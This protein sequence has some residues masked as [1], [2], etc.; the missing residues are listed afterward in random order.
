MLFITKQAGWFALGILAYRAFAGGR[1]PN[2]REAVL[3]VMAV[4]ACLLDDRAYVTW[5]QA[6]LGYAPAWS[7][8][9]AA[10][11]IVV[12]LAVLALA[13]RLPAVLPPMVCLALGGLTY[14]LYLVHQNL[15]YAVMHWL[16]PVGG[17]WVGLAGAV[18]VVT[19]LAWLIHRGVEPVGKRLIVR[20]GEA[21]RGR[22]KRSWSS[23]QAAE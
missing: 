1:S 13:V 9:F 11:K 2:L 8:V 14:P 15:G 6:N 23:V 22:F 5:M 17:R 3:G 12:M 4:A 19:A 21:V 18:I 16:D 10:A 20:L 7:P